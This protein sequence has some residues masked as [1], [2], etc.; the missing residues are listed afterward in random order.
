MG[1]KMWEIGTDRLY[2]FMKESI[3]DYETISNVDMVVLDDLSQDQINKF[4]QKATDIAAKFGNNIDL[5]NSRSRRSSRINTK[6]KDDEVA[7][8]RKELIGFI[9]LMKISEWF[10]LNRTKTGL[11]SAK[12]KS[13]SEKEIIDSLAKQR[14]SDNLFTKMMPSTHTKLFADM[15]EYEYESVK[16]E[17]DSTPDYNAEVMSLGSSRL[18]RSTSPKKINEFNLIKTEQDMNV[19]NKLNIQSIDEFKPQHNEDSLFK[20]KNLDN[21]SRNLEN[22]NI[23]PRKKSPFTSQNRDYSHESRFYRDFESNNVDFSF[24]PDDNDMRLSRPLNL[25]ADPQMSIPYHS[26]ETPKF[27]TKSV[28]MNVDIYHQKFNESGLLENSQT[29]DLNWISR[30]LNLELFK[31]NELTLYINEKSQLV[32]KNKQRNWDVSK[33]ENNSRNVS[34]N[35]ALLNTKDFNKNNKFSIQISNSMQGRL[36]V[37]PHPI[38]A[39]ARSC[40]SNDD[41]Y[42]RGYDSDLQMGYRMDEPASYTAAITKS[43]LKD[44]Q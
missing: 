12:I 20:N 6:S 22:S 39:A 41:L 34:I 25:L 27:A 40:N 9:A 8:E 18:R 36:N 13:N 17:I 28:C 29:Y 5:G 26:N 1:Y 33:T 21:F 2:K 32:V 31:D 43:N 37:Q 24:A 10:G 23:S 35:T 7:D 19:D 3:A 30:N 38:D 16:K 42:R 44:S 14:R 15:K 4:V 11:Y